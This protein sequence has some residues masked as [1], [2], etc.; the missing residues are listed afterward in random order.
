MRA[1]VTAAALLAA[2][3]SSASNDTSPQTYA[4]GPYTVTAGMEVTS[5]CVQITLHNDHD[6]FINSVAL[7]T[8]AG[9]HHSNWFFVPESDFF[10]DDGTFTCSDRNFSEPAAAIFGGVLFAQSTQATHEVQAFPPGVV[11]RVPAH[12]KLVAQIHLFNPSDTDLSLSPTIELVPIPQ[13]EVETQLAAIS[14][15]DQALGLPP[16]ENS[17]FQVDCDLGPISRQLTGSDPSFKIYYALAHYHAMGTGMTVDALQADDTTA[18]TIYTTQTKIGDSLGGVIDPA[19]DFTG[20]TH[21]RFACDYYNSSDATVSW[22]NGT[23][24]MCVFLAFSDSAYNWGGGVTSTD[25]P[26]NP[27]VVDGVMTY[28]HACN[29]FANDASR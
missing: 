28:T 21:L 29:V 6:L 24:E 26:G 27:T 23:A 17:R 1:L 5:D 11:I 15:E 3:T 10:G 12:S 18:T 19:F 7:T 8:G 2:C 13:S 22:G 14:F 4:F 9:F 16:R 20:N 25:S